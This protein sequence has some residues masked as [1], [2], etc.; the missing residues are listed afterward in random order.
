MQQIFESNISKSVSIQWIQQ[1]QNGR[2]FLKYLC[3][4]K[5][6]SPPPFF[7]MAANFILIVAIG[8]YFVR[9]FST[10]HVVLRLDD[11]SNTLLSTR[12]STSS[13]FEDTTFFTCIYRYHISLLPDFLL[14][15]QKKIWP[16]MCLRY[17]VQSV[18]KEFEQYRCSEYL[19]SLCFNPN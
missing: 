11:F 10:V 13:K 5:N 18:E 15:T 17:N 1:R 2:T 7:S 8:A 19:Y 16:F 12:R 14:P 4:S 3:L 6:F 9:C